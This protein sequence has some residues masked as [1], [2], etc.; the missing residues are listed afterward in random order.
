MVL[1]GFFSLVL[2][3]VYWVNRAV[4]LF[5]QIIANGHSAGTFFVFTAL[6]LPSVILIVLPMGAIV[7]VLYVGNRLNSESELVVVQATGYSPWRL[8]RAVAY[9]GAIVALLLSILAHVLV[10]FAARELAVRQV[11]LQNNIT[12]SLL[13][14]GNFLH[15]ADGVTFYV[16]DISPNGEL[17]DMFL[18]DARSDSQRTNYTARRA[19]LVRTESGG[20][21]V[22]IDGMAQTLNLTD[23]TL[24]TTAFSDFTYDIG[25]LLDQAGATGIP[26]RGLGTLDLLAPSP[27]IL[28]TYNRSPAQLQQLGHERISQALLAIV[29]VMLGFA[30][31]LT[32]R[33]SRFGMWPQIA[34]AVVLL[35]ILK[36]ADN[37]LLNEAGK[38]EGAWALCYG[39]SL[40]GLVATIVQLWRAANPQALRRPRRQVTP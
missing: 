21:L 25:A 5:D 11:D 6:S 19:F 20:A 12:A 34:Q 15:P 29:A 7:A 36:S 10:P 23:N 31:L 37:S 27:E 24:S 2:V 35:I 39:A 40:I 17:L 22:M 16:R 8:I 1:F 13:N 33:F 3:M 18:S 28:A 38:A 14:E 32:G 26:L 30:T 9:F 4:I